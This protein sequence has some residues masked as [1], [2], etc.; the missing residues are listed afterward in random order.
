[1]ITKNEIKKQIRE[2]NTLSKASSIVISNDELRDG[3][4]IEMYHIMKD[5]LKTC[6]KERKEIYS[7]DYASKSVTKCIQEM[8]SHIRIDDDTE[9][10]YA[11]EEFELH[12][13]IVCFITTIEVY[14]E[15]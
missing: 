4:Y 6:L 12:A 10:I 14:C 3:I 1:M 2:L 13:N 11:G 7:S 9:T 5:L 8:D 15:L